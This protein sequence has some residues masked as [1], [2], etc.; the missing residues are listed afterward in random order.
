MAILEKR[1]NMLAKIN[2]TSITKEV[3]AVEFLRI[4]RS[5]R[6]KISHSQIVLPKL[7]QPGLGKFKV[8]YKK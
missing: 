2:P 4:F 5:Q 7:G 6:H 1:K 3:D 8:T